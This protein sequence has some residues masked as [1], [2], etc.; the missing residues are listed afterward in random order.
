MRCLRSAHVQLIR[1]FKPF[2]NLY[3]NL[4]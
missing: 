4:P 3:Q 2:L 1:I